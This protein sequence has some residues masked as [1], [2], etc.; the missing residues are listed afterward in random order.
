MWESRNYICYG[1]DQEPQEYIVKKTFRVLSQKDGFV[2]VSNL[3]GVSEVLQFGEKL[4]QIVIIKYILCKI[5][6]D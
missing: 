1:V 2:F 4:E 6:L 3:E 5:E